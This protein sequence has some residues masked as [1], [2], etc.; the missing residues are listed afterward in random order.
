MNSAHCHAT[1]PSK[2]VL[3]KRSTEGF[4]EICSFDCSYFRQLLKNGD[5]SKKPKETACKLRVHATDHTSCPTFICRC[6]TKSATTQRPLPFGRSTPRPPFNNRKQLT[7][8]QGPCGT[9]IGQ[10]TTTG[11]GCAYNSSSAARSVQAHR[12]R[13][14]LNQCSAEAQHLQIG[15]PKYMCRLAKH[16]PTQKK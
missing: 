7:T 4:V 15:H 1:S 2:H 3:S 13:Q 11:L 12:R 16:R 9:S 5:G 10:S 6:E 14:K 8:K